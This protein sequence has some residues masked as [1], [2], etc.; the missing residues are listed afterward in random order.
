MKVARSAADLTLAMS[1][2]KA[3]AKAAFGEYLR[4]APEAAERAELEAWM[5]LH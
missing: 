1:T 5:A 2:A 3:E 4:L